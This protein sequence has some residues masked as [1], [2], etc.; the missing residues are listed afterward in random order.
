MLEKEGDMRVSGRREGVGGYRK[1]RGGDTRRGGE[2]I[3]EGEGR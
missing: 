2:V 1:G 3:Q